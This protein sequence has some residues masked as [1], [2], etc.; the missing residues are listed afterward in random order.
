M[1]TETIKPSTTKA[2]IW[3]IINMTDPRSIVD[4]VND[5]F[6]EAAKCGVRKDGA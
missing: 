5:L 1:T 3:H 2:Q 4:A 6:D